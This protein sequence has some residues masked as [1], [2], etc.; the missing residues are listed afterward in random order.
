MGKEILP[1]DWSKIIEQATYTYSPLGKA[2]EK[3]IKTIEHQGDKQIKT[4]EQH[5]KQLVKYNAF[6]EKETKNTTW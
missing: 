6:S 3:K 4:F 5:V 1:S 2:F